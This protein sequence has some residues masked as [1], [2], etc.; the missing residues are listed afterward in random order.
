M[1]GLVFDEEEG[2]DLVRKEGKKVFD[3][4]GERPL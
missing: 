4:V 3:K 2:R 1:A